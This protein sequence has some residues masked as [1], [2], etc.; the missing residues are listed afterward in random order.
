VFSVSNAYTRR[1]PW[2]IQSDLNVAQNY[3]VTERVG[4]SFSATFTNLFNQR[5]VTAYNEQIDSGAIQSFVSP[6]GQYIVSGVD[7]YTASMNPWGSAGPSGNLAAALNN[8]PILGGPV[9]RSS[10]YAQPMCYQLSRGIRLGATV[11]F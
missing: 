7:W 3:K 8:S 4:L 6:G 2:Y 11:T 9:L 1:T 5:S 10:Q